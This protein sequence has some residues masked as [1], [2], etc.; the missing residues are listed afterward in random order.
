MYEQFRDEVFGH[1]QHGFHPL[2]L[3]PEHRVPTRVYFGRTPEADARDRAFLTT[4]Q[5]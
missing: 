2:L 5:A 1:S 3:I 4:R